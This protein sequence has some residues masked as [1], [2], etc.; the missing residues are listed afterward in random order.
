MLKTNINLKNAA[1]SVYNSFGEQVKIIN[2]IS[3]QTITLQRDDLPVG[4]YFIRITEDNKVIAT[5]KL[6]ITD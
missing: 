6:L 1:L 4:I 2:N 5:E 3:G